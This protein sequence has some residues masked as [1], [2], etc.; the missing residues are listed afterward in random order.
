M[1]SIP[2]PVMSSIPPPA[3]Q[4]PAIPRPIRGFAAD[5]EPAEP[6]KAGASGPISTMS[7]HS[8]QLHFWRGGR[9]P[10]PGYLPAMSTAVSGI[11]S[12]SRISCGTAGAHTITTGQLAPLTHA[13][14]TGPA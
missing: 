14:A 3:E 4:A 12:M 9:R 7:G 11:L 5:P 13:R 8:G 1:S 10:L 2:R 6:G